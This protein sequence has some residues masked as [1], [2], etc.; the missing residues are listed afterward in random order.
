MAARLPRD[1]PTESTTAFYEGW[2]GKVEEGFNKLKNEAET[3]FT[4]DNFNVSVQ[5]R[6]NDYIEWKTHF[7][8]SK[9]FSFQTLWSN[10]QTGLKETND[11]LAEIGKNIKENVQEKISELNKDDDKK[12]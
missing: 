4:Q 10:I 6:D 1:A 8:N 12:N 9:Y 7:F 5:L 11:K 2:K 3:T